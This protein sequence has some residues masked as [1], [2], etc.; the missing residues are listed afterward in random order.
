MS[1]MPASS[2]TQLRGG[3]LATLLFVALLAW[4]PV[5]LA[6]Y[7]QWSAALLSMLAL[8]C[9]GALLLLNLENMQQLSERLSPARWCLYGLIP[10][11][12]LGFVQLV[13]LPQTVLAWIAPSSLEYWRNA[14]AEGFL[15]V[16]L[17]PT[18]SLMAS[19]ESLALVAL[20]ALVLL[21]TSTWRR[22]MLIAM[23]MVA[24]GTLESIFGI[25]VGIARASGLLEN[26]ALARAT[27]ISGTFDSPNH[28]AGFVTM[29][30]ALSIGLTL[31]RPVWHEEEMGTMHPR[32]I[33]IVDLVLSRRSSLIV[34]QTL[35]LTAIV[36]SGS[37]AALFALAVGLAVGLGV[38]LLRRRAP[39]TVT[40]LATLAFAFSV[41]MF[42]W[43]FATVKATSADEG[44]ETDRGAIVQASWQAVRR[45]PVLGFGAGTFSQVLPAFKDERIDMS[46]YLHAYND[47]LEEFVERGVLALCMLAPAMLVGLGIIAIA[48]RRR[49]GRRARA[50][51]TGCVIGLVAL[52]V[53]GLYDFS[54][55]IPANALYFMA[56]LGIGLKAAWLENEAERVRHMSR[57][58][59]LE[60]A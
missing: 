17:D 38:A 10:W 12:A 19:V 3:N 7:P 60:A 4:A 47:Y 51:L 25:C 57:R 23:L 1:E 15:P 56:L 37:H 29:T 14:G 54:L 40:T 45:Q 43:G 22:L 2:G 42:T 53:H 33:T 16:S 59:E 58:E 18:T 35:M 46:E 13:P 26:V 31:L 30:L 5:P 28:F 6:S 55:Q 52:L 11:V 49:R 32:L 27:G 34:A 8:G 41:A 24:V 50:L 21:I 36:W 44:L 39:G 48:L 9:L 20:L